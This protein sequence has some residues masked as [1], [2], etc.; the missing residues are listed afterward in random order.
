MTTCRIT[1]YLPVTLEGPVLSIV[2][3]NTEA[4]LREVHTN[5]FSIA[6][7]QR[8]QTMGGD[9]GQGYVL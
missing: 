7:Q 4:K 9:D 5:N 1:R 6:R 3:G 8:I 2:V